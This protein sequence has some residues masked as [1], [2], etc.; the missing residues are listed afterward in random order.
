MR[1]I[2]DA[3]RGMTWFR[4]ETEAEA[5]AESAAMQHAVEKY[6]KNARDRAA[7][8]FRPMARSAYFEQEIG[9]KA[10]VAQVMPMFLTL[11]DGDGRALVTAMLPPGGCVD[12]SFRC[13]I[14]G[15]KNEDPYTGYADAIAALG[16][17]FG[18]TLDRE[19]C[20]PYRHL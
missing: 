15:P 16:A 9:L 1:Y 8:S 12:A 7:L 2:C 20:Y 4:L 3:P 6:F 14:V 18:L 13:I 5:T 11:R 10:H 19:V 17:H